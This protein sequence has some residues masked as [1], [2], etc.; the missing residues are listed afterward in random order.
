M[1]LAKSLF[2]ELVVVGQ[3]MSL[4]DFNLY[5][6]CGLRGEFKDFVISLITKAE[7][8]LSAD[9]H[10]HLLTHE[11]LHKNSLYSMDAN[12]SLL[13]SPLLPQPPLLP[14]PQP[15]V[16]LVMSYH[17]SNFSHNRGHSCGNCHPNNNRYNHQ[18]RF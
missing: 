2:D 12:S 18:N 3:P 15:S 4:E 1:Q 13:S 17:N 7:P 11:F 5:M 14:T 9:L 6:F 10:N 16:H 8:L